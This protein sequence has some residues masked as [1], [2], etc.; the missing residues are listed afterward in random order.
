MKEKEIV[1]GGGGG[2]LFQLTEILLELCLCLQYCFNTMKMPISF[3]NL[4]ILWGA[5]TFFL[6]HFLNIETVQTF[7]INRSLGG[8]GGGGQN[9]HLKFFF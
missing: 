8:G 2:R 7:I 1:G 6:Q 9:P 3:T 4:N 5:T